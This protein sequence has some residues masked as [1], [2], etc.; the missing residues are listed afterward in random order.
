MNQLTHG[1]KMR[2]NQDWY[3]VNVNHV[4]QTVWVSMEETDISVAGYGP[5]KNGAGV[6]FRSG[7]ESA[8]KEALAL[9]DMW[10]YNAVTFD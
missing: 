3:Y 7:K 10:G 1:V 9:A 4:T 6:V 2:R 5:T 8:N